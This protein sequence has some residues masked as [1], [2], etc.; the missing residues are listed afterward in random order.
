[1]DKRT[2]TATW[3]DKYKR[4][5][6]N[7]QRDGRRR[8]FYSSTPGRT[9]QR[10]AN[11]K[12][13]E[14]LKSGVISSNTRIHELYQQFKETTSETAGTS[15]RRQIDYFGDSWIL[16]ALGN[17]KISSLCDQDIQNVLDKAAAA[18]MSKKTIQGIN[19]MI[20]KFLKYCRR[21]KA[22]AF[23][24][25]EVQIPASARLKGKHIL[26]PSDFA[27]LF[28]ED[29]YTVYGKKVREQYIHA[30][31]FM[32]LTGLRPGEL[33]GLR[34]EDIDGRRV[35][36]RRAVNNYGE[37]TQG[38]NENALRSFILSDMAKREL[39]AQI[40]EYP[41]EEYIFNMPSGE[42]FHH[43]WQRFCKSNGMA[44][45]SPYELRHTF[46]SVVKHLPAGEVK[47]L[48][49]H[50]QSMDTFGVYGHELNGDA[51]NVA[52]SVNAL[53]EQIL[54]AENESVV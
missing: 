19:G 43:H 52:C 15:F 8:S 35:T 2:N 38:K 21:C 53:F 37:T 29:T 7:V 48:V 20:N 42:V 27:T 34:P 16:P 44:I 12:A 6:I 47:P 32:L 45:T 28:R 17:K 5:Q 40:A 30:Y 49:G 51:E 11:A 22:T 50:S 33:R 14:W 26:Q 54:Q 23:R 36:I 10:E 3:S 18:G 1:M 13:D 9:G 4:W 24:P 39:D 25:E 31:R 41:G 46:V